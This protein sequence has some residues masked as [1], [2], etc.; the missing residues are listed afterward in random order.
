MHIPIIYSVHLD[1][2][3]LPD[4]WLRVE[5]PEGNDSGNPGLKYR[6]FWTDEVCRLTIAPTKPA[7]LGCTHEYS[8][9]SR[10]SEDA[11]KRKSITMHSIRQSEGTGDSNNI[12][13]RKYFDTQAADNTFLVPKTSGN[14][15]GNCCVM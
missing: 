9:N 2:I 14:R 13:K 6:N 7:P 10:K 4:G 11:K 15:C 3:G 12:P 8:K 1:M 5:E